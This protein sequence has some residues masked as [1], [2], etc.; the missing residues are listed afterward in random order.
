[1]YAQGVQEG[2]W[3][4]SPCLQVQKAPANLRHIICL[5]P[6]RFRHIICRNHCHPVSYTPVIPDNISSIP[7]SPIRFMSLCYYQKNSPSIFDSLS[8]SFLIS[9]YKLSISNFSF[10]YFPLI[11]NSFFLLFVLHFILL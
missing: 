11:S 4:V 9:L 5:Q 8:A 1:M 2:A 10:A 3:Q 6:K 7:P